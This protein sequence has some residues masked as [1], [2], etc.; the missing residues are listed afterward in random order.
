MLTKKYNSLDEIIR[1]KLSLFESWNYFSE[2]SPEEK[3][4]KKLSDFS[5]HDSSL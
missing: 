3:K 5:S 2:L 1:K 4:K